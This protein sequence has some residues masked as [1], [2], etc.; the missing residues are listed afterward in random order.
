MSEELLVHKIFKTLGI[1]YRCTLSTARGC[2]VGGYPPYTSTC[3]RRTPQQK[4]TI[5]EE[6][7]DDGLPIWNEWGTTAFQ[8]LRIVAD[9]EIC[10]N[11]IIYM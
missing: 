10:R 1:L 6:E 5:L 3:I 7:S 8:I 9:K 2:K 11:T 4:V